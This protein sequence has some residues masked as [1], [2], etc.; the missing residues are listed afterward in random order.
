MLNLL[1]SP[2]AG[3]NQD[4]HEASRKLKIRSKKLA[5]VLSQVSVIIV[6]QSHLFSFIPI[7][8]TT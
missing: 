1:S 5:L 8:G 4:L 7:K 2:K 6:D 3:S